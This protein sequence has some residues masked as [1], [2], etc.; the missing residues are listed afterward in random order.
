M[1]SLLKSKFKH[2]VHHL[3]HKLPSHHLF[4]LA[5]QKTFSLFR[6]FF[7]GISGIL[8]KKTPLS[9]GLGL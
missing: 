6:I 8:I 4:W 9:E 7:Q 1:I 3:A 5:L 2:Q